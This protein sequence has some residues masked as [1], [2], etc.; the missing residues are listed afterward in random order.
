M[1]N[2]PDGSVNNT[3]PDEDT[4][5]YGVRPNGVGTNSVLTP[6]PGGGEENYE[7]VDE[8]IPDGDTTHVQGSA[9]GDKDTYACSDIPVDV[10]VKGVSVVSM[11][12][13]SVVGAEDV[14]RVALYN[15]NYT[16]IAGRGTLIATEYRRYSGVLEEA[17]GGGAWTPARVN[18]A[19]FGAE[20]AV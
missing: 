18:S 20:I 13:L 19:E 8:S 17:P 9:N 14:R 2:D 5:V 1:I 15:G 10:T 16:Y 11:S 7:D 3:Y 4:R 6:S 12:K